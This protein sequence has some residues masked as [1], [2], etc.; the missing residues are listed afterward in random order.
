MSKKK[1]RKQKENQIL[2]K[3]MVGACVI[4]VLFLIT[5]ICFAIIV[6]G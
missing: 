4:F 5:M 3:Q 6:K 1:K 2:F